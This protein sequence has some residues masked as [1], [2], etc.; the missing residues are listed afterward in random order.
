[1][2]DGLLLL[3]KKTGLTSFD[4]LK[5]VK[6]AFATGKAGHTGTLDKFA[7]GLLL[8]LLG[9]GVK[10]APLFLDCTKE[11]LGTIRFG[12]ET[13]TLDPEGEVVYT[14]QLPLREDVE[15]VLDGFRG[16]ILQAPPEY[17]AVHVNGK[18]AHE[19]SRQG[20]PP[21]MKKR[22]VT[23]FS[24]ELLS[25][26]PP[27]A[28]IQVH[29]SAGTYIRSLARDIALAA[30]SR[31][32]LSALKRISVGNFRL[33]DSVED[34]GPESLQKALRPLDKRFFDDLSLP[35]FSIDQRATEG[36]IHGRPLEA[37]LSQGEFFPPPGSSGSLAGHVPS[38]GFAGVFRKHSTQGID[39]PREELLGLVEFIEG[40]W[41]YSHVFAG[42]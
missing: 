28:V 27:E 8:V 12:E 25:W 37:L 5:T 10:L 39:S 42:N 20:K 9:K 19:L 38:G 6:K 24:L 29:C 31:A 15:A 21:E 4:S 2:N 34:T 32:S 11:Y 18:R 36:F 26:E 35:H 40:R 33:Q 23:I 7:S 1:M 13:E 30:G 16:D 22:P 14:A 41:K 3:D 17:S